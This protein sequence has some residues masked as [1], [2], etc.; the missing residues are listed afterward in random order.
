MMIH[1][2]IHIKWSDFCMI[3]S[4]GCGQGQSLRLLDTL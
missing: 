3:V 2:Q 4:L 1:E